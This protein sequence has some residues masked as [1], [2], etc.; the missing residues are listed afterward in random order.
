ML[1]LRKGLYLPA[2]LNAGHQIGLLIDRETLPYF[3]L[4]SFD[5][6]PV[7]FRCV[8]TDLVSGKEF[9]FK[10]G[11]LDSSEAGDIEFTLGTRLTLV[12][13][14]GFRSEWRTDSLFDNTYGVSSE[15]YRPFRVQPV[16]RG[17]SRI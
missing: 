13:V 5:A 10:D 2:G 8:A 1:G 17:A 12:D 9:V 15:L 16:Q 11:S 4:T 14:A 3:G 6:L 7:A